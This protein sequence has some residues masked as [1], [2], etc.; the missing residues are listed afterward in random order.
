MPDYLLHKLNP[1]DFEHLIQSLGQKLIGPGLRIY[2]DGPDGGREATFS[3]KSDYPSAAA[4]WDG[5]IV[6]QCK[7]HTRP[8]GNVG[9]EAAWAIDELK[10]ELQKYRT[11][12]RTKP[13]FFIFAT[14]V[15]LTPGANGSKD[16]VYTIL[17]EQGEEL[18]WK[19]SEVW[20]YD[21]ICR[22]LQGQ[23]AIR[24]SFAALISPGD[25]IAELGALIKTGPDYMQ[26]L[27]SYLQRLLIEDRNSKLESAGQDFEQQ[28]PLAT[29]F[30]DLPAVQRPE[31]LR[32]PDIGAPEGTVSN[33]ARH[34]LDVGSFVLRKI[35]ESPTD[36]SP[37]KA[38]PVTRQLILG[39]P[40]QGKSTLVQYLCHLY[41][42]ALLVTRPKE[43]LDD[44]VEN[45]LAV[46]LS[47]LNG[48]SE[49]PSARRMPFRIVLHHLASDL[50][51]EKDL[52]I[53]EYIRRGLARGSQVEIEL[54][55]V[56]TW[57]EEYPWFIVFDG[58]DEVPSTSNRS[59][60]VKAIQDFRIY[61]SNINADIQLVATSRPQGYNDEFS[62]DLF[63][64]WH[65]APLPNERALTYGRKLLAARCGPDGGRRDSL[66]ARLEHAFEN[67]ATVRLMSSPLQVT[68][69]ATLVERVG[70]PPRERYRLFEEYYRTIYFREMSRL[71]PLS[72][73]LSERRQDVDSIHFQAG[74]QLQVDSEEAG[75]TEA[76]LSDARFTEIVNNRLTA[77]GESGLRKEELLSRIGDT[78]LQR[79]VFLVRQEGGFVTFE[80]RSLQEYMAA[81][82]IV[83][84]A[85]NA[86][87]ERL[88]TIASLAH[89]RNVLL[90]CVG[91]CVVVREHLL[92]SIESIC[93]QLNDKTLGDINEA[94][95]PGSKLALDIL[96]DG[97]IS[98]HPRILRPL[99]GTALR[100]SERPLPNEIERLAS[101][102]E[103]SLAD[104]YLAALDHTLNSS[105]K[106]KRT[107]GYLLLSCLADN[108]VPG[109]SPAKRHWGQVS[110][111]D[112]WDVLQLR[113][114][115]TLG[116]WTSQQLHLCFAT[117]TPDDIDMDEE[118]G[119]IWSYDKPL[120][121]A[122][123]KIADWYPDGEFEIRLFAAGKPIG[124]SLMVASVADI[125]IPDLRLLKGW[126]GLAPEWRP[127]I[128]ASI[129]LDSPS[130][131]SL[132]SAL[133][134]LA[135]NFSENFAN[136]WYRKL[137]WPLAFCIN[138]ATS[139]ADVREM[140]RLALTGA[141][142]DLD[143]WLELEKR[144][145]GACDLSEISSIP[146]TQ[147]F[148]EGC[149]DMNWRPFGGSSRYY[150][151]MSRHAATALSGA[152]AKSRNSRIRNELAEICITC[153]RSTVISP[154][155]LDLPDDLI[156]V[157]ESWFDSGRNSFLINTLSFLDS[158]LTDEWI[159]F[160]V[161]CGRKDLDFYLRES[162]QPEIS[163]FHG[164]DLLAAY[165][166]KPKEWSGLLR[167]LGPLASFGL[168]GPPS[169]FPDDSDC[170]PELLVDFLPLRILANGV[171]LPHYEKFA[172]AYGKAWDSRDEDYLIS[173][174][175]LAARQSSAG[176]TQLLDLLWRRS[177]DGNAPGGALR[178]MMLAL[179]GHIGSGRRCG[180]ELLT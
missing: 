113:R 104:L 36:E 133:E 111:S 106:S 135:S 118:D 89:W 22:F 45:T 170:P 70:E 145:Q 17:Q 142:G 59:Q 72:P 21:E 92:D 12:N 48:D 162:S 174:F 140:S 47:S 61:L 122:M 76:R 159:L 116:K 40:G 144:W 165:Q 128:A 4:G 125:L 5:Y 169:H 99:L 84:G 63:Q 94:A 158:P 69:M 23:D 126:D 164:S 19:G 16:Q 178:K 149:L 15:I 117:R 120:T 155:S 1:R 166:F 52:T 26:T 87:I 93:R 64:Y 173:I 13:D 56:N 129:F 49:L 42:A 80:I 32:T 102:Y 33:L 138:D 68:I 11:E 98:T 172:N 105:D 83:R 28:V 96:E 95:L 9:A 74:L 43:T 136:K 147:Y 29:V 143:A 55:H 151:T 35:T 2:G 6:V 67:A 90:F 161:K 154:G 176:D 124:V 132:H 123:H 53:V 31:V 131:A 130:A 141:L 97:S 153:F 163:S 7:F 62:T 18:G 107:G 121:T 37:R 156:D 3:G 73:L 79:L 179:D 134:Y 30:V 82:A 160:L 54:P 127:Y 114:Q 39:G 58:L 91:K 50:S 115:Q 101:L 100:L 146:E 46:L 25:L 119:F 109:L 150:S 14:N 27:A 75:G 152:R 157:Y 168:L 38:N 112:R 86:I 60:V 78:T 177:I 8:S 51:A 66:T 88:R 81:E 10:K 180:A 110:I 71:G 44:Q 85:D 20:D 148:I 171:S 175:G 167:F 77:V 41:A 103:E 24:K 137:P 57:L 34:L 108:N 65:L 139:L